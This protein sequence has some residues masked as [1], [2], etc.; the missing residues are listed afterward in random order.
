MSTVVKRTTLVVRNIE[1]SVAFYSNVLG[2]SPAFDQKI[3]M[4]GSGYPAG[5]A[6]DRIRLVML[7]GGDP[8]GSMIG[9]LEHL[10]P[11][12][13]EPKE[14]PVGIGDSVL[15]LQTDD[16]HRVERNCEASGG[17]IF[18]RP[19][20]FTIKGPDGEPI[21]M[22]SMTILDPDG[23]ILEVNQRHT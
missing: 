9:L 8:T 19:H 10:D 14:R 15:V 16:L 11:R 7:Q 5:K 13:P 17:S 4:S 1:R 6:G 3:A 12:L 21:R 18:S 22:R 2:Y 23:F 20:P